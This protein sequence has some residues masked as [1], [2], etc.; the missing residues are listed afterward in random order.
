MSDFYK[1]FTKDHD[2]YIAEL[3]ERDGGKPMSEEGR[4]ACSAVLELVRAAYVEAFHAGYQAGK[5][6]T[7]ASENLAHV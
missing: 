3:Q 5:E 1:L 2:Q 6:A 7:F 4:A